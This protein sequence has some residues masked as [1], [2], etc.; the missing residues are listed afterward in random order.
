MVQKTTKPDRIPQIPQDASYN[1]YLTLSP[2]TVSRRTHRLSAP[3]DIT[4]NPTDVSVDALSGIVSRSD[5]C[6]DHRELVT[7][8]APLCELD[9]AAKHIPDDFQLH[10]ILSVDAGLI[11]DADDSKYSNRL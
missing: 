6:P 2:L 11:K 3:D 10:I 1:P 9:H 5:L 4:S 8:V 7:I